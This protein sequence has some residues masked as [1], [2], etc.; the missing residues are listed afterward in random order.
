ML[1]KYTSL[2]LITL[3]VIPALAVAQESAEPVLQKGDV[4]RFIKTFPWA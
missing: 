2:L 3:L 4:E 1:K